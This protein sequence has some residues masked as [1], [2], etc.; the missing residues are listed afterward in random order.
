MSVFTVS[1]EE[2][3]LADLQGEPENIGKGRQLIDSNYDFK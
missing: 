2:T 1:L 3:L